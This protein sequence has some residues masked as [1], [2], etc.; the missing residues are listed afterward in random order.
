MSI[1]RSSRP[2]PRVLAVL[3]VLAL[4]AVT[5]FAQVRDYTRIV[6]FGDSLSDTG[7]VAHLTAA[8]YGIPVPSP[9]GGNYTLGRFTDGYDTI[10]A[11]Q[12]FFGVWVEQ[13]SAS[14]PSHPAVTDSLDG[15]TNYAFG[16]ALT[17]GGMST[18]Q[19]AGGQVTV[20]V[21]NMGRQITDYLSTHPR[22]NNK[23]LFVVWGG[24][25]DVLN[26]TSPTQ[27][28]NAAIQETLDVQRLIAAGATQILVLNLPPLGLTPRLNGSTAASQTANAASA[29][30]N[31]WLAT[32]VAVLNDFY[33]W[34]RVA[35]YHVNVFS[36][37]TQIAA[38]PSAL[39]LDNITMP[40][41]GNFAINPDTYLFW[42]DLHPTTHGHNL[43][44]D[45][46]LKALPPH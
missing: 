46:A 17:G 8:K 43:V 42:D 19:L 23:T 25:N 15:G 14:I 29:L 27:I 21:E 36:L 20:E 26:A 6:V 28:V 18:L 31:S 11:A 3:A 35:I 40:A 22:I 41:Q 5:A 7:N 16:F 10:P 32:G 9:V 2:V 1:P 13:L 37:F 44:A 34:R 30:Y 33:R 38:N 39:S 45:A 24:A 4:S 12:N